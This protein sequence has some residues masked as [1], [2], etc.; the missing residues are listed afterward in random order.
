AS[1]VLAE[2]ETAARPVGARAVECLWLS[3]LAAGLPAVHFT[4]CGYTAEARER[5]DAIG[6]ALFALDASGTARP[7][8]GAAGELVRG[9]GGEV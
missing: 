3:G 2:V 4:G 7:V 6:L 1:G 5:A 8:S 9:A